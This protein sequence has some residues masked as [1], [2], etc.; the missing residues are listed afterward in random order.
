MPDPAHQLAVHSGFRGF[1][2]SPQQD[3]ALQKEI[4]VKRRSANQV[5]LEDKAE[6]NNFKPAA[7]DYSKKWPKENAVAVSLSQP[8]SDKEESVRSNSLMG[9]E[10]REGE[11]W[12]LSYS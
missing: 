1:R 12:P 11:P 8:E 7:K 9:H 6:A 2:K 3:H 4:E 5:I 10:D